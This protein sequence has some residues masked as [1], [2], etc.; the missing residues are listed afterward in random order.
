MQG[1]FQTKGNAYEECLD[2]IKH[3]SLS[4]NFF[5]KKMKLIGGPDGLMC[6][7]S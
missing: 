4:T 7:C 1:V 5:S 6:Y 2:E 3:S